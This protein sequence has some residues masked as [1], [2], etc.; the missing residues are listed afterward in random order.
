MGCDRWNWP[1][2]HGISVR[3]LDLP[4]MRWMK[5]YERW[6]GALIHGWG[7]STIGWLSRPAVLEYI[8]NYYTKIKINVWQTE[9]AFLDGYHA[10]LLKHTYVAYI[11]CLVAMH[12]LIVTLHTENMRHGTIYISTTKKLRSLNSGEVV[13]FTQHVLKVCTS[14]YSIRTLQYILPLVLK[15]KQKH[16]SAQ[17]FRPSS[18]S[19]SQ[20]A[21]EPCLHSGGLVVYLADWSGCSFVRS[22][23]SIWS[24]SNY[25]FFFSLHEVPLR[26]YPACDFPVER[27]V[28]SNVKSC[29]RWGYALLRWGV[30]CTVQYKTAPCQGGTC[31]YC[32][33]PFFFSF[34]TSIF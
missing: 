3:L 16:E 25:F 28:S 15:K 9:I 17:I 2:I 14:T 20:M 10:A 18:S 24:F 30:L 22:F 29:P 12:G 5:R 19:T 4:A 21:P 13:N 33:N 32:T 23:G 8:P 34:L 6:D 31:M 11:S 1:T 26:I 7:S 27:K